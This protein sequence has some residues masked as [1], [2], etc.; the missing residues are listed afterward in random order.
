MSLPAC[1]QGSFQPRL[2][3]LD[4]ST[5]ALFPSWPMVALYPD[6]PRLSTAYSSSRLICSKSSRVISTWRG[7]EPSAWLRIP[8]RV[9]SSTKRPARE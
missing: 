9:I 6:S 1:L 7:L 4:G 3:S 5:Q 2:P 8:L